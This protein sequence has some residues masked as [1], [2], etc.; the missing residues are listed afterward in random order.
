[1]SDFFE[2]IARRESCRNYEDRPVES[3][4]LKRMIEAARLA[5]SAVNSQSWFYTVVTG[6]E[7]VGA[8]R[9][10]ASQAGMNRFVKTCP[11]FIVAEELQANLLSRVGGAVKDQQYTQIDLGL[12]VMQLVLAATEQGLSTCVLGWF[13]RKGLEDALGL[14]HGRPRLVICVG[15]AADEGVRPKKRKP[16]GEIAA[17]IE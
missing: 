2:L 3:G 8:V 10:C 5:P 1:M 4:K 17:F 6:K 15:Y 16:V 7:A 12:S 14:S 11:A 9:R 13:D